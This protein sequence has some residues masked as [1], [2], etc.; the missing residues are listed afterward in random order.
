[1][2][3]LE[4]TLVQ[5]Q[6]PEERRCEKQWVDRGADIVPVTGERELACA[7]AAADGVLGLDEKH[8]CTGSGQLDAR[9]KSVGTRSNN[10]GVVVGILKAQSIGSAQRAT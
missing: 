3:Q 8:R 9:R 7:R 1:M 5:G 10:Y 2:N 4:L 6:L